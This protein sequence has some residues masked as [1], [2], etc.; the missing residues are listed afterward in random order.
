MREF[1][2]TIT[3]PDGIH[4]RPA[5]LLIREAQKFQSEITIKKEDASGN[6]KKIFSVMKLAVKQ[7]DTI[8]VICEGE[9]EDE[10]VQVIE[11]FVKVNL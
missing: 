2:Y 1:E 5:G 6:A 4:A 10:A 3:D 9:D 8:K 7:G 11:A